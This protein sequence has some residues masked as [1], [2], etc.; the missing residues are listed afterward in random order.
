M[1]KF[2]KQNKFKNQNRDFGADPDFI[3]KED[4]DKD[5]KQVAWE[6]KGAKKDVWIP[7]NSTNFPEIYF[8]L[9]GHTKDTWSA[10]YQN[11][12]AYKPFV[13]LHHSDYDNDANKKY[14][15]DVTCTSL[16][17]SVSTDPG[18]HAE[19]FADH[20][21]GYLNDDSVQVSSLKQV[22]KRGGK[23]TPPSKIGLGEYHNIEINYSFSSM[24]CTSKTGLA[25]VARG[26]E[27]DGHE[28]DTEGYVP[29]FKD[30]VGL[31]KDAATAVTTGRCGPFMYEVIDMITHS[32]I[33]D[34]DD[35]FNPCIVM[36]SKGAC[37]FIAEECGGHINIST[38][39]AYGL[40]SE[41]RWY[42]MP[43]GY[44]VFIQIAQEEQ[45][46]EIYANYDIKVELATL[47][48]L[49]GWFVVKNS[50]TGHVWEFD[51]SKGYIVARK[52]Q[53]NSPAQM[54][55]FEKKGD[56]LYN[57][58]CKLNNQGVYV[59]YGGNQ[60]YYYYDMS[61]SSNPQIYSV[62][63]I[64]KNNEGHYAIKANTSKPKPGFGFYQENLSIRENI[65]SVYAPSEKNCLWDLVSVAADD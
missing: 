45:G 39:K 44:Q 17:A 12:S 20:I 2:K 48:E 10:D 63:Q 21:S 65:N 47:I 26:F 40:K 28:V 4:L 60:P 35:A 59:I 50:V 54:F 19:V 18:E 13:F 23:N 49:E 8:D 33:D 56:Y 38:G 61:F 46:R 11:K 16:D 64:T 43:E 22:P 51:E 27:K 36:L 53:T 5:Y 32:I 9:K 31:L 62:L 7:K 14:K 6:D 15:V 42:S 29:S 57:I 25:F 3:S 1:A 24:L 58:I 30:V 41:D 52:N 55:K 34:S 37:Q